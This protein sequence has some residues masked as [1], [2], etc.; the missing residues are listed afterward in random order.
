MRV[1]FG[2]LLPVVWRGGGNLMPP[3]PL[4]GGFL[5]RGNPAAAAGFVEGYWASKAWPLTP[6]LSGPMR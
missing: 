4:C 6:L 5:S 3:V 1:A 2:R